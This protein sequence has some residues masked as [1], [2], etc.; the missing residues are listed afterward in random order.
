ML[1]FQNSPKVKALASAKSSHNLPF[2][3][4]IVFRGRG[5]GRKATPGIHVPGIMWGLY[6]DFEFEIN[7]S[8]FSGGN[9]GK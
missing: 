3:H 4:V 8:P 7:A 9:V 2:M 5:G 6:E 1:I